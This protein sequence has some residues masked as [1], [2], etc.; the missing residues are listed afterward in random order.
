MILVHHLNASRSKRVLWLLEELGISYTVKHYTRE[1]TM[2]APPELKR[3]HPLGKS[4]IIEDDGRVIAETGAIF[5][6]LVEKSDGRC[7][8]PADR[9]AAL[10][11]RFFLHYAEGSLLPALIRSTCENFKQ[12]AAPHLEFVEQELT[13]RPW[14]AGDTFTAVDIMMSYPLEVVAAKFGDLND[15]P[16]ATTW[17]QQ[18]HLRPAY[19]AAVHRG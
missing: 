14:F 2:A 12:V 16:R 9:D 11:Y 7:G 18:M 3:V 1:P 19:L 4:P 13:A 17:L 6:Y 8:A 10:R 15:F 5:E